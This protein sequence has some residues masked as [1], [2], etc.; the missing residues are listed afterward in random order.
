MSDVIPCVAAGTE[1]A[2]DAHRAKLEPLC[3]TCDSS[4]RARW[5]ERIE[6]ERFGH[7]ESRRAL[8]AKLRREQLQLLH[9]K[10]AA[11]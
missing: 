4:E 1:A 5:M 7:G 11:A 6:M 10:R 9:E 8:L 3:E 2:V